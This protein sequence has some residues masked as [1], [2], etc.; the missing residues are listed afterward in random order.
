MRFVQS[1]LAG[2]EW[3][4]EPKSDTKAH[5]LCCFLV[6]RGWTAHSPR[7]QPGLPDVNQSLIAALAPPPTKPLASYLRAWRSWVTW[8][9]WHTKLALQRNY[10]T[11]VRNYNLKDR[12]ERA[13]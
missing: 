8:E 7:P 10:G 5:I 1:S 11:N 6:T 12:K 2:K 4:F 3:V 9:T 13:G